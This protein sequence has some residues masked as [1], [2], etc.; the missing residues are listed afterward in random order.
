MENKNFTI[1]TV[2]GIAIILV[3]YGHVIQ[4]SMAP[5]GEDFFLNPAFKIIYTFHMPLFVFISG[6]VMAFSLSRRSLSDAFKT[7]CKT[8]LIPFVSWGTLGIISTYLLNIIDGKNINITNFPRDLINDLL[9]KPSVWFLFT[10]FILSCML[11][12]SIKLGQRFGIITFLFIYFFIFIIPYNDYFSLF[13]IKWFYLFYVAGYL[14]NKYGIKIKN[15]S[16]RT[17]ISFISLIIFVVLVSHW[18]KYDYIYINK[19]NFISKNYFYDFFRII[20]RYIVAFLGIIIVFYIGTYFSKTKMQ[21][22]LDHIGIYSLDI[23]LIQRYIVEG[24]YPRLVYN[25]H[26][27]FDFNSSFFLYFIAP[28]VT[29]IFLY[30]CISISKLLI[31]RN[32]LLNKLLLG[33]RV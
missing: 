4:R 25:A 18:T 13:Y 19:M 26:I 3:V 28:V 17:V 9:L 23:Y 33:N 22:F 7:K 10:L 11:L 27:K 1:S 31:R 5:I 16:I 20:Y 29:A 21:Y 14:F 32:Y 2:R 15:E 24:L 30:I 6:Y 12:Y 8:L